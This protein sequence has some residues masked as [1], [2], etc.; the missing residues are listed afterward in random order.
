MSGELAG[1]AGPDYEGG[2]MARQTMAEALG[3]VGRR[4][5][6]LRTLINAGADHDILDGAWEQMRKAHFVAVHLADYYRADRER[7]EADRAYW[8]ERQRY[9]AVN[10]DGKPEGA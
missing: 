8:G 9:D 3:E 6:G 4:M 1:A 10:D 5:L 2:R 7:D